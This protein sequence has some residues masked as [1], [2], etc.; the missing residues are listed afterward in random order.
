MKP[1][2][3]KVALFHLV[4]RDLGSYYLV[5]QVCMVSIPKVTSWSKMAAPVPASMSTFQPAEWRTGRKGA[6]DTY[7]LWFFF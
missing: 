3:G 2:T 4:L 7:Q 5:T 1:R 6:K